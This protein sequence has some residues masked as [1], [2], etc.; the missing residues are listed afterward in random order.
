M[1]KLESLSILLKYLWA[2]VNNQLIKPRASK[3]K[4]F[5]INRLK[6]DP[7]AVPIVQ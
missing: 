1:E 4:D 7:L 3:L 2:K 5:E 6:C